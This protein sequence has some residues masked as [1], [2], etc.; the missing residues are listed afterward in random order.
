MQKP[1]TAQPE[2]ITPQARRWARWLTIAAIAVFAGAVLTLLPRGYSRDLSQIGKGVN[3]VVQI[4]DHN[5]VSSQQ[6]MDALNKL[7]GDYEGRVIFL[8]ADIY[9]PEG[10][11]FATAHGTESAALVFFAPNGEKLTMLHGLQDKDTIR[12]N[13]DQAFHY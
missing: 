1:T 12:K 2:R 8:V 4:H 6:L 13:I 3:A 7:R 9:T 10:K 5:Q 11:E